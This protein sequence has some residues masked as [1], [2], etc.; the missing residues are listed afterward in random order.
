MGLYLNPTFSYK[1]IT[2]YC[3]QAA[4]PGPL[5]KA[6]KANVKA[7]RHFCDMFAKPLHMQTFSFFLF[8]FFDTNESLY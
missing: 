8:F 1:E 3:K 4:Y 7:R 6:P 2:I 5:P